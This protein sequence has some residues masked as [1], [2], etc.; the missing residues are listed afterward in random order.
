MDL[1]A[2]NCKEIVNAFVK[3]IQNSLEW[4]EKRSLLKEQI[5]NLPYNKDLRTLLKNIDSLVKELSNAEVIA[6]R[7]NK[8]ILELPELKKVNE[9]IDFL[10]K[11][12]IMGALIGN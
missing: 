4:E 6:R 8:N 5:L 9:S 3:M 11:W 10:E 1:S 2:H 12:I 7:H